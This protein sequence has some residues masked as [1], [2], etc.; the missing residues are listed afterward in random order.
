[1]IVI[2]KIAVVYKYRDWSDENHK[3]IVTDQLMF[4]SRPSDHGKDN[5]ITH[6]ANTDYLLDDK[7]QIEYYKHCFSS[8]YP[9][10]SKEEM[11]RMAINKLNI[12]YLNKLE[13][14]KSTEEW[15]ERFDKILGLFSTSAVYDN[16]HLWNCFAANKKGF[17]VE[18]DTLLAFP[19]LETMGLVDYVP[20]EELPK[21]KIIYT[22]YNELQ[23][24][25]KEWLFT[26]PNR[27]A[28]ENEYRIIKLVY[29]SEERIVKI[30]KD[31]IKT[32]ILGPKMSEKMKRD[33]CISIKE[34]LP[35]TNIKRLERLPGNKYQLVDCREEGL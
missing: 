5:D 7:N 1:M 6:R 25:I 21:S 29:H 35:D 13:I 12:R 27:Y 11:E 14:N 30:P 8:E 18:I 28:K 34:N 9:L 22:D 19:E 3:R 31:A 15:K 20:K 23:Q 4:F 16:M 26:L 10:L 2:D 32:I 24:Y 33:I 17:C